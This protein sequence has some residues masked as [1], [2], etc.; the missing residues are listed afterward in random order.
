MP[1][2][3]A[4]AAGPWSRAR[5]RDL[6]SAV[7]HEHTVTGRSRKVFSPKVAIILYTRI[8]FNRDECLL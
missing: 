7:P 1:D 5:K 8:A 3:T 6:G 2:R 4:R